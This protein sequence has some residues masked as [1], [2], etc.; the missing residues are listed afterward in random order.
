VKLFAVLDNVSTPSPIFVNPPVPNTCPPNTAVTCG[1]TVTVRCAVPKYIVPFS[2]KLCP[3]PVPPTVNPEAT[4]GVANPSGYERILVVPSVLNSVPSPITTIPR[5]G[6]IDVPAPVAFADNVT[7][8]AESTLK[9][10]DPA[11]IPVPVTGIPGCKFTVLLNPVT[12][13]D[14]FVTTPVNAPPPVIPNGPAVT[15]IGAANVLA[16]AGV[17]AAP[18]INAPP[19]N[20]TPPTNVLAVLD[21]KSDPLPAL[22]KPAGTALNP[23]VIGELITKPVGA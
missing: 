11:A 23:F 1:F 8:D 14:P 6:V 10:Y 2:V 7:C 20:C 12:T 22:I 16:V 5:V 3:L 13:A 19:F 4:D 17:V 9:I 18:A 15:A 21:S